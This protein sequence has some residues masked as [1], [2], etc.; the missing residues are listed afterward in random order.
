MQFGEKKRRASSITALAGSVSQVVGST[1]EPG[2]LDNLS[3]LTSPQRSPRAVLMVIQPPTA[4]V[5]QF[6]TYETAFHRPRIQERITS[7]AS[8]ICNMDH[9]SKLLRARLGVGGR[10][11][12]QNGLGRGS[13]TPAP[14]CPHTN[15]NTS[16]IPGGTAFGA[17]QLGQIAPRSNARREKGC[18]F[19]T[20]QNL[21]A[22]PALSAFTSCIGR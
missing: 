21:H 7:F 1:D 2:G 11:D 19:T 4:L 9:F 16:S 17:P 18:R 8:K 22:D 5:V 20:I 6:P 3:L 15:A 14:H 13:S 10:R 12:A